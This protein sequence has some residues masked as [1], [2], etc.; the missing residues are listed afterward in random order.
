MSIATAP[1]DAD[2]E[3][4]ADSQPADPLESAPEFL[5]KE[6][7]M[8]SGHAAEAAP[9]AVGAPRGLALPLQFLAQLL[10]KIAGTIIGSLN[11]LLPALRILT[12]A[13]VAAISLKITGAT[14]SAINELPLVGGVLELVGLVSLLNFLARNALQQKKRAELLSRIH[15]LRAELIG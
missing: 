13:V 8:R 5:L 10:R 2:R 1:T 7:A 14:L 6:A 12:L 4:S 9:P 3:L 11:D 15:K